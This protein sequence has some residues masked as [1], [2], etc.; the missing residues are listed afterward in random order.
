MSLGVMI[1]DAA[2]PRMGSRSDLR[3]QALPEALA[4]QRKPIR[5]SVDFVPDGRPLLVR[6]G[7]RGDVPGVFRAACVKLEEDEAGR[8]H[9]RDLDLPFPQD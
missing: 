3:S 1:V 9:H 5:E 6:L 4:L 2:R 7:Q 8:V